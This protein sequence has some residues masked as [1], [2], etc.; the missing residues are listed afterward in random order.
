M[1]VKIAAD[2]ISK[3][4]L[5][6]NPQKKRDHPISHDLL[7]GTSFSSH[8]NEILGDACGNIT[9]SMD[10]FHQFAFHQP[11]VVDLQ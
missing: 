6:S 3:L 1:T 9:F 11:E 7:S 2:G 4:D 5:V 10:K 8:G